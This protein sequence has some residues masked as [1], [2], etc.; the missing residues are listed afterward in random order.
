MPALSR[1]HRPPGGDAWIMGVLNCTPDSFSDGG[2]YLDTDAAVAHGLSLREAGARLIDVGGESTRPGAGAVSL[3]EELSR[4][5]PVVRALA[6][7][8]CRVSVDTTKAAVMRVACEAGAV[9][10]NDVTALGGDA[11]ALAVAAETGVDVC[12]M[13]MRGTPRTMQEHPHYDDVVVEVRDF[14]ARRLEACLAAGIREDAIVLDPG[15]GFGKRLEDNLALIAHLPVFRQAFGL[16]L[17]LGV[18]RK[19]FLGALT[20]AGV[21]DREIE[22]AAAVGI[23]VFSGADIL[24]VHDVV[25]QRRAV[26]VASALREALSRGG[27]AG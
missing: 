12:L 15:I 2:Q 7:A 13:H 17:M 9:M 1:W 18:S 25:L 3:E 6:D 24:R 16:P 20:G 8:G 27:P 21:G 10:I 4:V 26:R 11:D 19:S 5:I 14:L 23:G 22:T